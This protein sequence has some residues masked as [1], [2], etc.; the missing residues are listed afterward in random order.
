MPIAPLVDL[1]IFDSDMRVRKSMYDKYRQINRFIEVIADSFNDDDAVAAGSLNPAAAG[2]LLTIIDYGCGK[3]YLTFLI[4]YYFTHIRNLSVRIFGYDMKR[5]VVARCNEIAQKYGYANIAFEAADISKGLPAADS[6]DMMIALHA[7]DTAT[8]YALY[9]AIRHGVKHIF[10]VPCC[11]HEVNAKIARGDEFSL[12]LR[13]GLY[14]ERFSALLTDAI[15]CEILKDMGYEVDV[16]EF[17]GLD[18]TPKNAMIRARLPDSRLPYACAGPS[19]R[20]QRLLDDFHITHKLVDLV[21]S[22]QP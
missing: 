6:A 13:H 4:Y 11:Q 17:V 22:E 9:N 2:S 5:G 7:C 19:E 10:S 12:L 15:R 14:K 3:S 21:Y 18:N 8:D 1:G 16:L 20:I